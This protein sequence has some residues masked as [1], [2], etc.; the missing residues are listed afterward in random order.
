MVEPA[1]RVRAVETIAVRNKYTGEVIAHVPPLKPMRPMR[2][3]LP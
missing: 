1:A 3:D 2:G